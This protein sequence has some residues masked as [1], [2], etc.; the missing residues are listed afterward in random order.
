MEVL[1]RVLVGIRVKVR[2]TNLPNLCVCVCVYHIEIRLRDRYR[3]LLLSKVFLDS[4]QIALLT[5]RIENTHG[6]T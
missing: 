2:E 3:E 4:V 6:S 1:E 5:L